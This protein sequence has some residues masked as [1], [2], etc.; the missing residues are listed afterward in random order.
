MIYLSICVLFPV[1]SALPAKAAP[2]N[3]FVSISPQKYFV[4]KIG[5]SHVQVS[6]L[7]PPGTDPHTFEPKPKQMAA[8]AKCDIYFAIGI[9][10]EKV[11]LKRI[12]ST[13]PRM[14]IVHTDKDIN[15]I[16]MS[17]Q[18]HDHAKLPRHIKARQSDTEGYFDTHVWLAPA[19]VKIQ[20]GHI[21]S[22]LAAADPGNRSLYQANHETF[23]KEI[24][25]LDNEIK[26]LLAD[27]KGALFMVF[28][29]SWG[30]FASAYGLKQVPIE[31]EGKNPKPA[32]LQTLIREARK[33]GIRTV[34]AQPQF[35]AK[36]AEMVAREIGGQVVV[37]DPL[38]EDWA[39]NLRAVAQKI[40]ASGPGK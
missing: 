37:V 39:Q 36:S 20:A 16:T 40:R 18:S 34:F 6:V 14:R 31:I 15:K 35:S 27:S 8:L 26:E 12:A 2:L 3:V 21:L 25:T 13:N 38:A 7:V 29:P 4:E 17:G 9:D 11:W 23:L 30:Y 22:A 28:H 32:Q 33:Q 5:G 1:L 19:P 24:T 10:F